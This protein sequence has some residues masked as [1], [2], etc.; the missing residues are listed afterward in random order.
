MMAPLKYLL[1]TL[2]TCLLAGTS[3]AEDE[4]VIIGGDT[5]NGNFNNGAY[6]TGPGTESW[7]NLK[8]VPTALI[9]NDSTLLYDDSPNLV[10]SVDNIVG[11]DT[12][13]KIKEGDVF[14]LSYVWRDAAGFA[15]P[16]DRIFVRLFTTED[17]TI[18]GSPTELL[19][20][21][22]A[23]TV[24]ETF[25]LVKRQ[26]AYTASA[27]DTGKTLFV[28]IGIEDNSPQG[29]PFARVDNFELRVSSPGVSPSR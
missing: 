22:V 29:T 7:D 1:V 13:Y 5:G 12:G 20:D 16:H 23:S 2:L 8:G 3:F 18:E 19:L 4:K 15:D 26:D 27:A 28:S 14:S 24:N 6:L 17:N 21:R 9:R 11:Q 10:A 25:E